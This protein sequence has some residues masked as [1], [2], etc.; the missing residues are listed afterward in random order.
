M[1]KFI[2]QRIEQAADTAIEEGQAK[3]NAYFVNTHIYEKYRVATEAKLIEDGY[4][5]I[6]PIK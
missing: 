5:D 2:A 4:S 1:V 6:I 3:Y